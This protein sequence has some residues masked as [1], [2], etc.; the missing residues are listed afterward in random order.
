VTD[1]CSAAG[2]VCNTENKCEK[3]VVDTLGGDDDPSVQFPNY[4]FGNVIK[5][6]SSRKLTDFQMTLDLGST[7]RQLR[8]FVFEETAAS[9]FTVRLETIVSSQTGKAS[10]NSGPVAYALKAG[11]TYFFGV[12]ILGG[13]T[14]VAY[15]DGIPFAG[16]ASFGTALGQFQAEYSSPLYSSPDTQSIYQMK[17]TTT[18]P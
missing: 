10:F 14:A 8:W 18:A 6:S 1:D 5:V 15:L 13:N 11:K 2:S 7:P 4:V 17:L 16:K 12:R 3:S 9:T